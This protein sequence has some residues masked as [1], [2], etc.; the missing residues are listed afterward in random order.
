MEE[1][2]T[3]SFKTLFIRGL[4]KVVVELTSVKALLLAFICIC[5]WLNRVDDIYGLAA[6]LGIIGIREIPEI[7]RKE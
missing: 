3:E 1:I 5:I 2:L 7:M 6:A 4:K